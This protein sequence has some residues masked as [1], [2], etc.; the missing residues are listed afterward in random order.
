MHNNTHID[1]HI[2]AT[3]TYITWYHINKQVH[4]LYSQYHYTQMSM[5]YI[6]W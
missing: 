2:K 3:Q 1:S 6:L 5:Q 4:A